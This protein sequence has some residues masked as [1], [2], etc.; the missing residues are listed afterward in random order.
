MDIQGPEKKNKNKKQKK[1]H[2]PP[3]RETIQALELRTGDHWKVSRESKIS[4]PSPTKIVGPFGK[5]SESKI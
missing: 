4:T 3:S 1:R 5:I 2:G